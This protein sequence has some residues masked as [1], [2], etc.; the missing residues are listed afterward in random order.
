MT[1]FQ[2]LELPPTLGPMWVVGQSVLRK[3]YSVFDREN[4]RVGFATKA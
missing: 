2:P 1:A 4:S 3:Y